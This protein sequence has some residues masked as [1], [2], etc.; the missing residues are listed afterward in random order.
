[1]ILALFLACVPDDV[2][3]STPNDSLSTDSQGNTGGDDTDNTNTEQNIVGDW[4]SEGDN[5]SGLFNGISK[6]EA[7]FKANLSYTA[8]ATATNGAVYDF[9]GTY[10]VDTSTLPCGITASQTSPQITTAVGIWQVDGNTMRYEVAQTSPDQ[11]FS[12]PTPEGGFGSTSGPNVDPGVNIQ[13]YVR[14]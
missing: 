13:T 8:S 10:T 11:G 9:A 6:V 14:M 7:H 1:M 3:D 2:K 4:L 12:P 5:L